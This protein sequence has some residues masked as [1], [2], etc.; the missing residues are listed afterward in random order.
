VA[1]CRADADTAIPRSPVPAADRDLIEVH[2][3]AGRFFQ[4]CLHG[5]WVPDY[6]ADRGLAAA[7][8]PASPWKIGYAP[9]TWTA[10]TDYLRR[11]GYPS[12]LLLESGLVTTDRDGH[13]RD[14][15][16]DRLMIPLRDGEGL[17]IAFIGRR[18]PEHGDDHGPKYLN[19]PDTSL[20]T[21]GHV[22]AG[23]AE[24]H[25]HLSR[26]AQ[27]V[28]VE[29]PMDAIAV[30]VAAPGLYTGVAPCGTSLT[31][32]QVSLLSSV[33]DLPVRGIRVALDGDNAGRAAAARAY[34]LIQPVTSVISAVVFP[35]GQDPA[36]VLARDGRDALCDI[37]SS[38]IQPLADLVVDAVIEEWA[39]GRDLDIPRQFGALRA[40]AKTIAAM[41]AAEVGPQATRLCELFIKRYDWTAEEVTREVISA[42]ERRYEAG[43]ATE[44]SSEVLRLAAHARAPGMVPRPRSYGHTTAR[45]SRR[46]RH[47]AQSER[48]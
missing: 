8:L 31:T 44:T 17:A 12:S 7:L 48:G 19:S 25:R 20:F 39:Q 42:I 11:Q 28:L 35:D 18:H 29:G 30:T 9:A 2:A 41:S 26:G 40:A 13:L 43:P 6:L 14:R 21:K 45:S 22:L 3:V 34:P 38:R 47:Q 16:R 5:S 1:E 36:D 37:L 33:I 15:F 10:L 46:S 32:T 4:A 27:P 23:L 24:G